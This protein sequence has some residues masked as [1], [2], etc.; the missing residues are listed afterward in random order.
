[1]RDD[2]EDGEYDIRAREFED[3]EDEERDVHESRLKKGG[4]KR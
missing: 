4:K 2:E 1:V 3:L